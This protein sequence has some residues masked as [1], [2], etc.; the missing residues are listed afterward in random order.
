[1]FS[2]PLPVVAWIDKFLGLANAGNVEFEVLGKQPT[3]SRRQAE[4]RVSENFP[5]SDRPKNGQGPSCPLPRMREG[6]VEEYYL[7]RT[8]S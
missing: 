4:E 7:C 2:E 1:M 3:L 6:P 8:Y 5:P